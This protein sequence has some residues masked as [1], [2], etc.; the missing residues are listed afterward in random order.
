MASPRPGGR[1]E[2]PA[3]LRGPGLLT[4]GPAAVGGVGA[5]QGRV[6]LLGKRLVPDVRLPDPL[7][8]ELGL[9]SR[10]E[11]ERG[12]QALRA[13]GLRRRPLPPAGGFALP[14]DPRVRG[15]AVAAGSAPP[16][17]AL[18]GQ[19]RREAPGLQPTQQ[20]VQSAHARVPAPAAPLDVVG[21]VGLGAQ[22]ALVRRAQHL[23]LTLLQP[24][25][26]A[27]LGV[28]G[29]LILKADV[30]RGGAPLRPL[31]AAGLPA[32]GV[33]RVPVLEVVSAGEGH[34]R[35]QGWALPP[36]SDGR[37]GGDKS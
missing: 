26:V 30:G 37:A 1:Q 18:S 5:V 13:E 11:P 22:G 12:A 31:P 28:T 2:G 3:G 14:E 27:G 35:V 25:Q 10:E 24:L 36:I 4:V 32:G 19:R 34:P 23:E 20:R 7:S 15:D 9:G 21:E 16:L 17:A 8:V 33:A 29:R 6:H